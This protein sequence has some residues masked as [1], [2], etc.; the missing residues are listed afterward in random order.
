MGWNGGGEILG[1]IWPH[2][3][4]VLPN[5]PEARERLYAILIH[6]LENQDADTLDEAILNY[7]ED[8]VDPVLLRILEQRGHLFP[9][10]E[11]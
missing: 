11:W 3:E 2:I 1:A 7:D 6:E 10:E 9:M 5:R 4:D 8:E